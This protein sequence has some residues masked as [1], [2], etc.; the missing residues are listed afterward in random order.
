[1]V[2]YVRLNFSRPIRKIRKHWLAGRIFYNFP[3]FERSTVSTK[4][5]AEVQLRCPDGASRDCE[6]EGGAFQA[7]HGRRPS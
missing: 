3:H 6:G 4:S 5:A 7:R 1:M 2:I